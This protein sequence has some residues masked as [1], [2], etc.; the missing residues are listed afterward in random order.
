[1]IVVNLACGLANRMFQ[2]SYYLYL[3]RH[4][5][6]TWVDA[7]SSGILA[8]EAVEWERIF[9]HAP[10]AQVGRCEAFKLGG[11]NN[12]LSRFRRR[13]LPNTTS[14]LQ[15]PTAFD[16]FLPNRTDNRKYVI[17]VFQNAKMVEEVE[18]E[19][20]DAF[21]FLPFSDSYNRKIEAQISGCES[22][23]IHIRKGIDYQSRI[24]YQN[25]CP[26]EYYIQAVEM[27]KERLNHP[28]FFVFADNKEWVKDH[29]KGFEYTLVDGNPGSGWGAHFDLQLMS[30]CKH[31]IISNSTYSWWAAFL[32]SN[33]E[34]IVVLPKIWFNP[35]SCDEYTSEKLQCEKWIQL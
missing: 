18:K 2:Y 19:V 5:Y 13:Y 17:G 30:C 8:H 4:D 32:N 34:K 33:K 7:Y 21:R 20:L 29:L 9:P 6:D 26:V 25:T 3:K 31:N 10:L 24:W 23:G 27:M 35:A 15:M 12:L 22:V 16:A 11:G 1:M 14:I 28:R